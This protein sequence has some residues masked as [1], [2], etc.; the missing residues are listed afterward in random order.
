M[1]LT[2]N[3]IFMIEKLLKNLTEHKM[4]KRTIS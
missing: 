3:I 4:M 1:Y 2:L